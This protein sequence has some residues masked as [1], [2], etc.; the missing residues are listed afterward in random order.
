MRM[1]QYSGNRIGL[2]VVGGVLLAVGTFGYLRGLDHLPGLSPRGKILPERTAQLAAD[3]SWV[4]WVG[5]LGMLLLSL[6]C[7]RWLLLCLGWGRRGTRTGTGTALLCIGLKEIEG[8]NRAGVRVVGEDDRLRVA[9]TC[10]AAADVGAVVGKLEGD[11]VGRI[12][13]EV[14]NGEL[15]AVVRV[16][17]RR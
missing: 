5:A 6:V 1:R 3:H 15:G 11:L 17:V 8:I 2:A 12:R 16:H 13:R 14:S 7:L 9:L 4:L 10:P